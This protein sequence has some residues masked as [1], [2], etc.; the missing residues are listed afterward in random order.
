MLEMRI[1]RADENSRKLRPGI[2]RAH[3][4]DAHRPNARLRRLDPEQGRGLP[5]LDTAPEFSLLGDN[6]V[7]I[8][9]IG[10]SGDLDP[11]AAASDDRQH[12]RSRRHH[13]HV[14]LELRHI[15]CDRRFFRE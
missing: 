8:Q 7:L 13:P 15:F 4:H 9:R 11:S 3:I 14:V 1:P 5:A 6:E 12:G 10:M 2:G